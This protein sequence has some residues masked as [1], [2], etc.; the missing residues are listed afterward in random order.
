[1]LKQCGDDIDNCFTNYGS[2]QLLHKNKVTMKRMFSAVWGYFKSMNSEPKGGISIKR[3]VALAVCLLLSFV[4]A[5]ALTKVYAIVSANPHDLNQFVYLCLFLAV[6]DAV[7]ILL[8]LQI[9][10]VEKL[11]DIA[12]QLKDSLA[13]R[14][15]P[16]LKE[17]NKVT[18]KPD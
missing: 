8:V 7:M 14:A 2:E 11:K 3:N 6:L 15:M 4:E 12:L 13:G 1:M 5:Y 16:V 10:S 9:T 18:D 17:E